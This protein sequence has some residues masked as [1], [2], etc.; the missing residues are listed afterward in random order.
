MD[1]FNRL[2]ISKSATHRLQMLKGR[3]GLTPNILCRIAL[4]YSLNQPRIPDPS[5][6]DNDGQE[7][8]RS[9]LFGEWDPLYIAM[10]KMRLIE[11]GLDPENDFT[12]QLAAHI[13]RGV[14]SIFPIVK[15]LTDLRELIPKNKSILENKD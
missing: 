14:H 4:I 5:R 13:N 15:S 2:R 3:T 8:N 7:F 12:T 10:V 1:Y 9:T 11:D 6:Y